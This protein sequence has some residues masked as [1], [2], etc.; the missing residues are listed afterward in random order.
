M[1]YIGGDEIELRPDGSYKVKNVS[2]TICENKESS[3][4]LHAKRVNVMKQDLFEAKKIR[5]RLFKMPLFWLPSSLLLLKECLS[6]TIR[7]VM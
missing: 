3:W 4:D 2:V 5:F 7:K 1:W 6:R